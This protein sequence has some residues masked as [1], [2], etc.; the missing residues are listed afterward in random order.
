MSF[1]CLIAHLFLALDNTPLSGCTEGDF[2]FNLEKI[3]RGES[4]SQSHEVGE[5]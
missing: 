3:G 5:N 1:C 2:F 4:W